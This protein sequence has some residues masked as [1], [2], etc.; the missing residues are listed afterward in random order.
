MVRRAEATAAGRDL[1]DFE[2]YVFLFVSVDDDGERARVQFTHF[3]RSERKFDGIDALAHGE[4]RVAH[5]PPVHR[6]APG[7]DPGRGLAG[8]R[9]LG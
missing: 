3:L 8:F 7:G 2:W 4:F 6:H 5:H 9:H 1:V